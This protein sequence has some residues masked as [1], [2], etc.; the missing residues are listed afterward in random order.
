ME[1]YKVKFNTTVMCGQLM[2]Q[3]VD[4]LYDQVSVW[5]GEATMASLFP[6]GPIGYIIGALT[7]PATSGAYTINVA[8]TV[9]ENT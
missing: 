2:Y 8:S 9:L 6:E 4:S 7:A 5:V 3:D 1:D